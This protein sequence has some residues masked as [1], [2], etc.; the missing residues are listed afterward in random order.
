M[1]EVKKLVP[2]MWEDYLDFF[3][4]RAFTDG[5]VNKG[6]YCVW[7]HWTDQH[8]YERSLLPAE[9]RP[10]VK[11]NFAA[12]LIREGKLNG[13]AAYHSGVMVG[14][15]NA[16]NKDNYFR[17]SENNTS[18]NN[19]KKLSIVCFTV[20]P[21][22]RGRGVASALLRAVCEYAA[23]S[24]Y[25]YVESYPSDKEFSPYECCG[26][27]SMYLKQGFEVYPAGD[28]IIVRKKLRQY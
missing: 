10:L 5:N 4:N 27:V 13:F 19:S 11:K 22:M 20:A 6:C 16:D 1:V 14:F 9:E 17:L 2:D 26:N 8:E 12:Q 25:D 15:C 21:E 24:G 7:H 23:A 3:E 28:G 18:E